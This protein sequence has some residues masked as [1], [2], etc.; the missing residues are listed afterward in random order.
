MKQEA[1]KERFDF[2]K[3]RVLTLV[4]ALVMLCSLVPA[5]FVTASA[6]SAD[7]SLTQGVYADDTFYT[8]SGDIIHY[9]ISGSIPGMS[10][11]SN[12]SA[13]KLMGTPTT[14][15]NFSMSLT[16]YIRRGEEELTEHITLY[17]KVQA[18]P[19]TPA[20]VTLSTVTKNYTVGDTVNVELN[21]LSTGGELFDG[22]YSGTL[23]TGVKIH[24]YDS[25]VA[26][27]GQV[28]LAGTYTVKVSVFDDFSGGWRYQTVVFNVKDAVI[29]PT[30]TKHPTGETVTEGQTALFVARADNADQIIWYLVSGDNTTTYT[31]A[32]APKYFPGLTVSGTSGE[33]LTLKNIP[34][35]LNGWQA[36][37]QFISTG[38]NVWSNGAKITVKKAPPKAPKITVQPVDLELEEGADGTLTV[39]AESPDGVNLTYQ[40]YRNT[41]ASNEG[42]E[43]ISGATENTYHP[44][45]SEEPCYY[46]CVVQC[47]D[48]DRKS[49]PVATQ[50]AK[51]SWTIP[52]TEETTEATTEAT[53]PE[54]ET[55]PKETEA[56][57]QDTGKKKPAEKKDSGF[58]VWAL[59]LIIII[60]ILA[61]IA[62]TAMV[63][64]MI[65][66]NKKNGQ[67]G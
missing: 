43:A 34:L 3:R 40:W 16:V 67:N 21:S 11:G 31:A 60:G 22:S 27:D 58:P 7:F 12:G 5:F 33:T 32:D 24:F 44:E 35:S 52:E 14:A 41:T 17:A 57:K 10:I 2:M 13:I 28:T 51:V 19:V 20:P 46:Y 63:T 48:G 55:E 53:E 62:A 47:V 30:I 50:C 66:K 61:L 18:A 29:L 64:M 56:A 36:K 37:A 45:F 8:T 39:K 59:I 65:L 1:E 25:S 38:G 54:E 23:P 49:D 15:G 6:V 9:D 4:L 26:F 42:G